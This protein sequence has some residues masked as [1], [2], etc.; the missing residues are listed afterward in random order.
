M[1][2]DLDGFQDVADALRRRSG[3]ELGNVFNETVEIVKDLG[4]QFD[5]GDARGHLANFRAAGLR[6]GSP[7][8]RAAR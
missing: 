6:A 1:G 7:F 5:A 3:V 8:A 2:Q 4:D